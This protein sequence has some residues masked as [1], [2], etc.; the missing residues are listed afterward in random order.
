MSNRFTYPC[1]SPLCRPRRPVAAVV[2]RPRGASAAAEDDVE[3]INTETVQ[4][5]ID[6]T[7]R[8]RASRSTSSWR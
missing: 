3:V 5:Y 8:S 7:A 6:A 2:L 1:A 4:V